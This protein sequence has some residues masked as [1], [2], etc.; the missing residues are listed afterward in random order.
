[1]LSIYM[2]RSSLVFVFFSSFFLSGS[3]FSFFF[4]LLKTT[5]TSVMARYYIFKSRWITIFKIRKKHQTQATI[6]VQPFPLC[7]YRY[8][9]RRRVHVICKIMMREKRKEKKEVLSSMN[10]KNMEFFFLLSKWK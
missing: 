2:N 3:E 1:M 6:F 9:I 7:N 4:L 8:N 10:F 5:T